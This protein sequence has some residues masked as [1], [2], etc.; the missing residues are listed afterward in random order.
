[1]GVEEKHTAQ[2]GAVGQA[3]EDKDPVIDSTLS[4]LPVPG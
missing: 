2:M 4:V 3:D 1:M